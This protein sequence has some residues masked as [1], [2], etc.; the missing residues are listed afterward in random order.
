MP[1]LQEGVVYLMFLQWY[2]KHYSYNVYCD[3][4]P[5]KLASSYVAVHCYLYNLPKAAGEALVHAWTQTFQGQ[6][7]I[8]V[9][10]DQLIVADNVHTWL[11]YL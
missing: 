6:L 8:P 5:E 11:L 4:E 10:I 1:S 7:L 3:Q 9:L 2:T